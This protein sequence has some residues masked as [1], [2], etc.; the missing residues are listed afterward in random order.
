MARGHPAMRQVEGVMFALAILQL[1]NFPKPLRNFP[2]A[3]W[4]NPP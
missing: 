2:K 1:D 4:R 3:F